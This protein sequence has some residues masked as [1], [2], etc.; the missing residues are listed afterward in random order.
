M[1]HSAG[2]WRS[3]KYLMMMLG[4]GN[5]LSVEAML[6]LLRLRYALDVLH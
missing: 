2:L 5:V 3:A 6:V 1:G 4:V